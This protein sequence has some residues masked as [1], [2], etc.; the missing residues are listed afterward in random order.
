MITCF[1]RGSCVELGAFDIDLE[2][3]LIE[4]VWEGEAYQ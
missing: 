1:V 4:G 3:M 2:G